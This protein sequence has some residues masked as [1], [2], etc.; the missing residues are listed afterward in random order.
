MRRDELRYEERD[1]EKDV[2]GREDS[3][4][5]MFR[6]KDEIRNHNIQRQRD[7]VTEERSA[8]ENSDGKKVNMKSGEEQTS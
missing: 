4:K 3:P 5:E 8:P 1:A 2:D 7:R 6:E